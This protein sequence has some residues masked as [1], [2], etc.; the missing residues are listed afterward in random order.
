MKNLVDTHLHLYDNKFDDNREEIIKEAKE[1]LDFIVNISCDYES[2]LQSLEYA[3]KYDFMYLT[4]GYHPVDIKKYNED[5]MKKM[6][7]LSKNKENKIIALGEIGL[8]YYWM[9]DPKE[10][11]IEFF[12]KQL[13]YAKEYNLPVVIHTR[14][15]L[16]DTLE[17][18]TE[19]KDIKGILH[20]YP[21]N[22]EE[23]KH[24][25][26]R[27][28]IGIGGSLTF[29]NNKITQELVLNLP[30]ENI[31]IETDSPYLTPMPFRGK[32]NRPSYV[33]YVVEK[34]AE[35]KNI[36]VEIVKKITTENA[37]KVYNIC[38]K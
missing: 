38:L 20:C 2:F 27:F 21:G 23:V 16:K 35:I 29:K 12:K 24:L 31:V 15:A 5:D 8:D 14:D 11:Q 6:L 3:K 22:Y 26:D 7:E 1:N 19:Y 25:L 37:M 32:Q 30:L 18:L 33:K 17:I 36:D 9:E 10:I 4:L 28:Y 34:I 13:N